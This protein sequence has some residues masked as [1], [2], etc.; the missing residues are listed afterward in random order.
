[1]PLTLAQ[2]RLLTLDVVVDRLIAR[3]VH[4]LANLIC[5]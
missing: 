4:W 1:M 5:K 2:Y 3:G